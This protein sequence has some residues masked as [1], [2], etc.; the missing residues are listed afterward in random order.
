MR[1]RDLE[2][3]DML[4]MGRDF[5]ETIS[6]GTSVET[7]FSAE[8]RSTQFGPVK[9]ASDLR[10]GAS[11][12]M[13]RMATPHTEYRWGT[14]ITRH[15]LGLQPN[16][17]F[18]DDQVKKFWSIEEVRS[19]DFRLD[20]IIKMDQAITA[21]PS[22]AMFDDQ[23]TGIQPI[24][25]LFTGCNVWETRHGVPGENLFPGMTSQQGL[26]PEAARF[27]RV[28]YHGKAYAN[29]GS[30]LAPTKVTYSEAG[31]ASLA[32]THLFPRMKYWL[33]RLS[34][35]P[36]PMAGEWETAMEV[37]PTYIYC[38]DNAIAL[39][40]NT[41]RA[42]GNFFAT[43]APNGDPGK[44]GGYFAGK[45]LVAVDALAERAL[46]PNIGDGSA[47][48]TGLAGAVD[49][50]PVT[51]TDDA[52][53]RGAYFYAFDP[54]TIMFQCAAMMPWF[55]SEWYTLMPNNKDVMARYGEFMGNIHFESFVQ[56][57]ILMP[58]VDQGN[59]YAIV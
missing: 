40:D 41:S 26:D 22:E 45:P 31:D 3:L 29:G 43:M 24:K 36:I 33:S 52:G 57:G 28:D 12:G 37:A 35:K 8:I 56:N 17:D 9:P 11:S 39:L 1:P 38:T 14:E 4:L 32:N 59:N 13:D 47:G 20:P 51:E 10:R 2:M 15:E 46:Y 50:A 55:E 42:H 25:S 6:A 34:W 53:I 44:V 21:T 49:R 54:R 5:K 30:Q 18:S 58:A 16:S 19:R 23:G 48:A 27:K 7:N